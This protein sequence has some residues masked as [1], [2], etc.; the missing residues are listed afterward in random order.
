MAELKRFYFS[1]AYQSAIPYRTSAL[2]MHFL[3]A[4]EGLE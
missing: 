3:A 4:V 1:D 2:K